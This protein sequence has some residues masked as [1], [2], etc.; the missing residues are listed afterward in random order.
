MTYQDQRPVLSVGPAFP[1]ILLLGALLAYL[2]R[3]AF[4]AAAELL[5]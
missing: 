5:H 4:R 2:R 3:L 1:L